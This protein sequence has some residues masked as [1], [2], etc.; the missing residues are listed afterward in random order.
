MIGEMMKS[1]ADSSKNDLDLKIMKICKQN[2]CSAT[3]YSKVLSFKTL[4]LPILLPAILG[5]LILIGGCS[6][7][8][9]YAESSADMESVQSATEEA[10]DNSE[11][12]GIMSEPSL[13]SAD[14]T[15]NAKPAAN[16]L[17]VDNLSG[18]SEQTLGSQVTD[19][20]IEGKELLITANANFKVEDVVKSTSA[21]ENLTRQQGG[22]VA[23]SKTTNI[24]S[25]SR[26]FN[27]GDQ[28]VTLTTYYRQATMTVRIPREKVSGFLKQVQQQ[29]AF[30]NEQE[31]SAQD[32]TLDIY[33]QQLA[34]KLNS[35]MASELSQ[36]RLNSKNDKDQDSN[37][38]TIT[39]TYAARQQQEYAQLEKLDIA[40]KIKYSTIDFTFTQP[41]SSYKE[42]TQNLDIII[43][44]ERPSF[45]A[46]V[47]GAFKEGWNMLRAIALGLIQLWWLV[48]LFGVFYL[49]YR[50][51]KSLYRKLFKN[52]AHLK[53][54]KRDLVD[55]S[56][57]RQY[58]TNLKKSR[59]ND[60]QV[61]NADSVD[62]T[63]S[64]DDK[65]SN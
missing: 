13:D 61:S 22:Y 36:E 45:A 50:M 42:T 9:E 21:I 19:I 64:T 59:V 23:L 57:A 55:K 20:Q 39:A 27:K 47:G 44:A 38:D 16:D 54:L 7:S 58:S 1:T 2:E 8:S 33:R 32:V 52:D 49:I 26:T 25:D 51:I 29:V 12:N 35:D 48:V 53:N 4:M 56:H 43:D 60:N 3:C 6:D 31:F 11:I 62:N 14:V 41:N 17:S 15:S 37:V 46:Q 65:P 5:S 34:S 30:L 28:N 24:E 10:T 40:D 18:D 63:G